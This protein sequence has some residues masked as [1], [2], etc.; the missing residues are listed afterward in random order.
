VGSR[1]Q[2]PERVRRRLESLGR[3]V[4]E[5]RSW[6]D[7]LRATA[8]A[9]NDRAWDTVETRLDPG[10]PDTAPILTGA[11]IALD[12]ALAQRW[13]RRLLVTAARGGAA[14]RSLNGAALRIDP[15]QF[16]AAAVSQDSATCAS[17]AGAA[18]AASEA[19]VALVGLAAMPVLQACGRELGN[20]VA[21]G[22]ARGYCPICG[23]WPAFGEIRG[24]ER[25]LWLRCARCGGDWRG[26]WRCCVYCRESDHGR[27]GSLVPAGPAETRKVDTCA[28]CLGYLKIVTV[29]Q[30]TPADAVAVEDLATVD[31][32]LAA[33][34]RGYS[35]A[36][37][38]GCLLAAGL[39]A[40]PP[41]PPG[42]GRWGRLFRRHP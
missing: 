25:S 4:P 36:S 28:A 29:L 24:L 33:L 13:V 9:V 19:L 39:V 30:P 20:R 8:E 35:R 10:R 6:L 16:L 3:G 1:G 23:S 38:T 18:G 42:A 27:L 26:Q 37:R 22:W 2:V 17:L 15:L 14:A 41:S 34:E 31:L 32:D 40:A 11:E 7:L 21:A 12:R 5:W